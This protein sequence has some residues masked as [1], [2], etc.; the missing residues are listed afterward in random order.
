[1]DVLLG[2]NRLLLRGDDGSGDGGRIFVD[3][4]PGPNQHREGY[5]AHQH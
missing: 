1:L 3:G 5:Y 4:G 2:E